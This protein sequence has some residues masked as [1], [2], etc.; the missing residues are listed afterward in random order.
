MTKAV[1]PIDKYAIGIPRSSEF[2]GAVPFVAEIDFG[3]HRPCI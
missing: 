2:F 3:S 1:E